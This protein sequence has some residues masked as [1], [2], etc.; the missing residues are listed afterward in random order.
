MKEFE[1]FIQRQHEMVEAHRTNVERFE[2]PREQPVVPSPT[3]EIDNDRRLAEIR[4]HIAF[5]KGELPRVAGLPKKF[6]GELKMYGR[7]YDRG[8]L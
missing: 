5:L 6:R 7:I 3:Q 8:E 1:L 4:Q 2:V